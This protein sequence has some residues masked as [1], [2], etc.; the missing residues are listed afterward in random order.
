[1]KKFLS[2]LMCLVLGMFLVVGCGADEE[3]PPVEQPAEVQDE[4]LEEEANGEAEVE[5][6]DD[7]D[8]EDADADEED[9]EDADADEEDE[10][11]EK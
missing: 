8:V 5:E 2:I 11:E 4:N 3:A 1:M 9:E 7:A 6:A 10:E